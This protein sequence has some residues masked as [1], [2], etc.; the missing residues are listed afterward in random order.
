MVL[1]FDML[2]AGSPLHY[3]AVMVCGPLLFT[4][5]DRELAAGDIVTS[6]GLSAVNS[7]ELIQHAAEN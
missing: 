1:P 5:G 3:A 7:R 4:A 2:M 6:S